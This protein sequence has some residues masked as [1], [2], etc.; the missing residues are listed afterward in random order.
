MKKRVGS[1][2]SLLLIYAVFLSGG[3]LPA[4]QSA[5]Q[6][7]IEIIIDASGSMVGQ[8]STGETKI[9]AA[10][11]AVAGLVEKLPGETVL[12]FRA[13][14]HQ[15]SREKHDCQDTQLLTGFGPLENTKG[16]IAAQVK[17]LQAKGY[18]P[19]TY[20]LQKAAGDFPAD[21][22]G[23]RMLILVSDGRETCQGD[24]CA[25]ARALAKSQARLVIH[26]VGFGVDEATRSQLDCVARAAGG[27]YFGA[28]D[29][30][31]LL[32]V[33][34]E[35]VRTAAVQVVEKKGPGRLFMKQADLSGHSVT[36][37]E[38]GKEAAQLSSLNSTVELPAGIYNV[39]VGQSLWKSVEVKAEETTVLNPGRLAVEN[40]SL[41]GHDIVEPET[42][43]VQGRVSSLNQSI[44]L[45][46]GRYLVKFGPLAWEVEV[47]AG[48]QTVLRPGT[49]EVEW[50]HYTGHKVFDRN[51]QVVGEVSNIC[52]WVPL[53][54]GDYSID[55]D[56]EKISFALKERQDLKFQRKRGN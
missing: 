2:L 9:E 14:G 43:I 6:R 31:Q 49:V 35:A 29:T 44:T 7:M 32:T 24:P 10:K 52:N 3:R 39:K 40:A 5:P 26:T 21:F 33:L 51:G 4:A 56:G 11:K 30:A 34:A 54:P 25:A 1:I 17:S 47:K 13:Y 28:A 53:P 18:T 48:E 16:Q 19:I 42:G 27:R 15:S 46:P 45:I 41:Q 20:V 37:A 55:I 22:Q 50:A 23:E 8:L 36:E 12:S 38:T